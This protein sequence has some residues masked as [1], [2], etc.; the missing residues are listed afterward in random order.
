MK[1]LIAEDEPRTA[2]D[3]ANTIRELEAAAEIVRITDSI[4]ET[5][6]FLEKKPPLDLAFFDIQLADGLSF[7]VFKEVE[8]R[9]PVIFCT[10][11]DEYAVAAFQTNGVAYILKPFDEKTVAAAL[12]KVKALG[13]FYRQRNP[14]LPKLARVVEKLQPEKRTGFLVSFQG[15]FLPVSVQEIAF[16][17]ILGDNTWLY[18]FKGESYHVPHTLEELENMLDAQQFFRANRQYLINFAAIRHVENDFA[19]KLSVKLSLRTP[20]PVTVSKAKATDFLK[21]MNER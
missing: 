5:I 4:E 10:A 12:E 13:D 14:D 21:W 15:R 7:E 16:F 6:S 17:T 11:F 1:I 18:N 20:D 8:I 2:I 19:R 3:L 9:F